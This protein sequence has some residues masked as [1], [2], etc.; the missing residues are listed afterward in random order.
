MVGCENA[1]CPIQC[2]LTEQNPLLH[3]NHMSKE[4]WEVRP[5][6]N[7]FQIRGLMVLQTGD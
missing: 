5:G 2:I 3:K 4:L 6:D 7:G 1:L